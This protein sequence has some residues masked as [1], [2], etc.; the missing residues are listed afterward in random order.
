MIH[1]SVRKAIGWISIDGDLAGHAVLI[2]P[3]QVATCAHVLSME[4]EKPNGSFRVEL[5]NLDLTTEAVVTAWRPYDSALSAGSDI[6]IL[7]LQNGVAA[8]PESWVRLDTRRLSHGDDVASLDYQTARGDGDVREGGVLDGSGDVMSLDGEYFVEPGLSGAGLFR[9]NVGTLLVGLISGRPR[10]A[11]QTTGYAIPVEYVAALAAEHD[12]VPPE[13]ET[14]VALALASVG[15]NVR[16]FIQPFVD[17]ALAVLAKPREKWR[18]E[19]LDA[20]ADLQLELADALSSSPGASGT[21]PAGF[22]AV[23]TRLT[24]VCVR[25]AENGRDPGQP[26]ELDEQMAG[27]IRE[28]RDQIGDLIKE[29]CPADA[30]QCL[31]QV[32]TLLDSALGRNRVRLGQL[33]Q[34]TQ[35]VRERAGEMVESGMRSLMG[36][37]GVRPELAPTLSIFVEPGLKG[38]PEMVVV[39]ACPGGFLMW[40]PEDQEG[41]HQDEKQHRVTIP[42]KFALG[43]F[44]LTFDEYDVF[45]DATGREKPSDEGWGR[46]RHPVINVSWEDAQA[47]CAWMLEQTGAEYRLPSEAKWEYACRGDAMGENV[48][49]FCPQV[50]RVGNG[51]YITADE[52]NFNGN[53]TFNGSPKGEYRAKTVPVDHAV[54]NPNRFGLWQMH[55]NVDEWCE[56]VF[57][58]D[59][60]QTLT[61]GSA[62]L[63]QPLLEDHGRVLRGGSWFNVPLDLRSANRSGSGPDR[64]DFDIGFRPAR[65]LLTP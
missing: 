29:D 1:E 58:E 55:G 17:N 45:C 47:W 54:F 26:V 50:A 60:D 39:P 9:S 18:K 3:R 53:G 7:T 20:L 61:D 40:S 56:D 33:S 37:I 6:A 35:T 41:R 31:R 30:E 15:D 14:L 25:T 28:A 2:G 23:V 11:A 10:N 12:R 63:P 32:N 24:T 46:G 13:I 5:P 22:A 49:E 27:L 62:H 8:P 65:T 36:C 4:S 42:Q 52:A 21:M 57:E 34:R 59:Y 51:A 48:T 16:P 43:R 64:R 19:D 38:A 44:A